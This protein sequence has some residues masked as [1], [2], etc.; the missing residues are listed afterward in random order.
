M[1]VLEMIWM[2]NEVIL[3]NQM[4]YMNFWSLNTMM[5]MTIC[6]HCEKVEVTEK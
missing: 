2:L 3:A 1:Q 5:L 4:V 6:P